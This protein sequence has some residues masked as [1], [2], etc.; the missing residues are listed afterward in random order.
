MFHLSATERDNTFFETVIRM[1]GA[2]YRSVSVVQDNNDNI[3]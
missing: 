2:V 1:Y 3:T